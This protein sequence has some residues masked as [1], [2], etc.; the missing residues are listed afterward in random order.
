MQFLVVRNFRLRDWNATIEASA[1]KEM[2][3]KPK[4]LSLESNI[5][6]VFLLTLGVILLLS[7]PTFIIEKAYFTRQHV[8]IQ[9]IET[10]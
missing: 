1:T 10:T 6:A 3:S 5:S 8:S 2:S 7:I 4:A 9:I